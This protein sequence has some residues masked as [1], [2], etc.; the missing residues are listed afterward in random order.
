MLMATG[1]IMEVGRSGILRPNPLNKGKL[2]L[3]LPRSS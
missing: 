1:S 2:R 3:G